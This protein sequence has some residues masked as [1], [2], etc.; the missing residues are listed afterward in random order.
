MRGG[1]GLTGSPR[2]RPPPAR[3]GASALAAVG[4]ARGG[5]AA[6]PQAA[7]TSAQERG[8]DTP[9][10]R[11]IL[12]RSEFLRLGAVGA[13]GALVAPGVAAR[14]PP[15]PTPV[16]APQGRRPRLR[17]V[18]RDRGAA[19][20]RVLAARA[21]RRRVL[22][23][24]PAPPARRPR[25]RRRPPRAPER[26]AR[27]GRAGRGRLRDRAARQRRSSTRA[28]ILAF[29]KEIEERVTGVYLDGV[30]R[31]TDQETRLLLG[32]LLVADGQHLSLLRGLD[33]E[34]LADAGLRDADARR[35]RRA[36]GSTAT[37]GSPMRPPHCLTT[38]L[39]AR[40]P[41][42]PPRRPRPPS[43]PPRRCA[44]RSRRSTARRPYNFAG[45]NQLQTQIE[46]GAPADVFASASP[47]E[48]QALFRAGR[49]TRP[50][51]FATNIVVMLVPANNPAE[52]RLDLLDLKRGPQRRLAVGTRVASRSAPTRA[53]CSPA[54]G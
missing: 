21:R 16:P 43:T 50:V 42:P 27:R 17:A 7:R 39:A 31:T 18:G 11:Q 26:G 52:A 33:G 12:D 4:V 35:D 25:R 32:R 1:R 36:N 47:T 2:S 37:S 9:V 46:R 13:A 53:S 44:R 5:S 3:R 8:V 15:A 19:L 23:A 10:H 38:L 6:P 49:C 54:C 34:P 41:R 45:S 29:G 40:S 22:Q 24:R 28:R 30:A 48:A 20:R 51:T 14:R